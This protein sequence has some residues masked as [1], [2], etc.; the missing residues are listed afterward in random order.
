[1]KN[2]MNMPAL[3]VAISF[4]FDFIFISILA[5]QLIFV[6]KTARTEVSLKERIPTNFILYWNFNDIPVH[7][8][9]R[10]SFVLFLNV[11]LFLQDS[12]YH[13]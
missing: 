11:L 5:M 7:I 2:N 1:M 4:G 9:F 10:S 13:L 3:T 6:F 8:S 12:D